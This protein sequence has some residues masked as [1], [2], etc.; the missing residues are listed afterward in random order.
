MMENNYRDVL[1]RMKKI[2]S[3]AIM[4]EGFDECIVGIC[5]TFEGAIFLYS[6]NKIIEKLKTKMPEKDAFAYFEENILGKRFD[7][8]SPVFL[9]DVEYLT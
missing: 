4:L 2:N 6:E 5:E 1:K 9:I 7:I 3:R 8:Y